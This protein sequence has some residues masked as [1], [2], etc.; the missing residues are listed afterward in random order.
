MRLAPSRSEYSECVWRWTKLNAA[1]LGGECW[2]GDES[3]LAHATVGA[4]QRAR[5]ATA[6]ARSPA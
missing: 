3:I 5:L 2:D 4:S 6:P 1:G